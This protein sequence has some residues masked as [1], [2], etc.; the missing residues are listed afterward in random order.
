MIWGEAVS[1]QRSLSGK[2]G[3]WRTSQR[4]CGDGSRG[5]SDAT[6]GSGAGGRGHCQGGQGALGAGDKM[7]ER[8]SSRTSRRNAA[9]LTLTL[10]QTRDLWEV[11]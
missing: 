2:E 1:L 11:T 6:A 5:W 10:A 9:Q 8:F 7:R 4:S 3:D